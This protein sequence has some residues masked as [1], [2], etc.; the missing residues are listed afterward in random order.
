MSNLIE[1]LRALEDTVCVREESFLKRFTLGKTPLM[2]LNGIWFSAENI[3]I[4]YILWDGQHITDC[5][6]WADFNEWL[7]NKN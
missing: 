4:Y 6:S 2:G 7:E 5:I 1:Q 3:K